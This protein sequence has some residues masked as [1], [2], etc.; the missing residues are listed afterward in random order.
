MNY[1]N[2][3]LSISRQGTD[4]G[5]LIL[6]VFKIHQNVSNRSSNELYLFLRQKLRCFLEKN[7]YDAPA[8]RYES[9]ETIDNYFQKIDSDTLYDAYED[10]LQVKNALSSLSSYL[11]DLNSDKNMDTTPL[12]EELF[13]AIDEIACVDDH[14]RNINSILI[15]LSFSQFSIST[16]KVLLHIYEKMT[17]QIRTQLLSLDRVAFKGFYDSQSTHSF[18]IA[19][20][21]LD[22]IFNIAGGKY[23]H[24]SDLLI[25]RTHLAH[26]IFKK[27]FDRKLTL[28]HL[29]SEADQDWLY[30]F[31]Q[32]LSCSTYRMGQIHI[33]P[34]DLSQEDNFL[35][36]LVYRKFI[37]TQQ[38][39]YLKNL[40]SIEDPNCLDSLRSLVDISITLGEEFIVY[41]PLFSEYLI[42]YINEKIQSSSHA[43][44]SMHHT[45][46][47]PFVPIP[48]SIQ[49]KVLSIMT[50]SG[51][52][53]YFSFDEIE[54][55]M[56]GMY[57][58]FQTAFLKPYLQLS[59]F[60]MAYCDPKH[61]K[62]IYKM[63]LEPKSRSS[64]A[65]DCLLLMGANNY[66]AIREIGTF[67]FTSPTFQC[68]TK[69]QSLLHRLII[70]SPSTIVDW[71]STNLI[72]H[73][74]LSTTNVYFNLTLLHSFFF[75]H[76]RIVVSCVSKQYIPIQDF[77]D[78]KDRYNNAL[79]HWAA[80]KNSDILELWI[81]NKYFTIKH[82]V[83]LTNDYG[84]SVLHCLARYNPQTLELWVAQKLI[85]VEELNKI[86]N[87][88]ECS[89]LYVL[90]SY[91]PK[92]LE[93]WVQ[94][95]LITAL[96]LINTNQIQN[97]SIA[98]NLALYYPDTLERWVSGGFLTALDFLNLKDKNG[99]SIFHYLAVENP[100]TLESW[101]IQGFLPAEQLMVIKSASGRCILQWIAIHSPQMLECLIQHHFFTA[102]DLLSLSDVAPPN[103]LLIAYYNP[104]IIE[105]W[106]RTGYITVQELFTISDQKDRSI[107]HYLSERS[108]QTIELWVR[109]NLATV[110]ELLNVKDHFFRS[111]LHWIVK[112]NCDILFRWVEQGL[113]TL[114]QLQQTKDACGDS[115]LHWIASVKPEIFESWRE[116]G[117]LTIDRLFYIKNNDNTSIMHWL[118]Y[119]KPSLFEIWSMKGVLILQSLFDVKNNHGESVFNW[120]QKNTPHNFNFLK[121]LKCASS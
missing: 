82:F 50:Q 67:A 90:A 84:N 9:I 83:E 1:L 31:S 11:M 104:K 65:Q 113:V 17:E 79:L 66:D 47:Y 73:E 10:T 28:S 69:H 35:D 27:V 62:R 85:T 51:E 81:Q 88:D 46:L 70:T 8:K 99:N 42:T 120:L 33:S 15:Y 86:K 101:V 116:S 60:M 7:F 29:F 30:L 91:S 12:F 112:Y 94:D 71:L 72:S 64:S 92:T 117:L 109:L 96:E 22:D 4:L 78:I 48:Y 24:D 23:A 110:D 41:T 52:P 14:V 13:L 74:T 45:P 55:A 20:M 49:N 21:I 108:S 107:L 58:E 106:V 59:T 80:Q 105:S 121:T 40:N 44:F 93:K 56:R 26:D 111:V 3:T 25:E 75:Y 18:H 98:H 38:K 39:N 57:S 63:Y 53:T 37:T 102:Y 103:T 100:K 77:I 19:Y 97:V 16:Q 76:P 89:I 114:K 32:E 6:P 87:K 34:Q 119:F 115:I 36:F 54:Y 61:A 95:N 68:L 5:Q 2:K 118:T 43:D